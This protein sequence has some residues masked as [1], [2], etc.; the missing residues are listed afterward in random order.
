VARPARVVIHPGMT[1]NLGRDPSSE[2]WLGAPHVSRKHCAVTMTPA[3][4]L[5]VHD[6]STNGTAHDKGILKKGDA[7]EVG[8]QPCV[9]D[10][11]GGVT[12]GICFDQEQERVFVNSQGS[13]RAFR[14][15]EPVED[16]FSSRLESFAPNDAAR[17]LRN[18]PQYATQSDMRKVMRFYQSLSFGSK[19]SILFALILFCI[20][21]VIV[22]SVISGLLK[23]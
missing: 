1:I 18:F 19:V 5:V 17:K 15:P 21:L 2:M 3:G 8:Q 14:S 9:F 11:G 6:Y 20:L 12:V 13:P 23:G 10:F 16:Q 22:V 4:S 7:L